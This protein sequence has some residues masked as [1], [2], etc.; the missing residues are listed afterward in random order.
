VREALA[1]RFSARVAGMDL[2][3]AML[4]R[5]LEKRTDT[6][7]V[8]LQGRAEAIPLKTAAVDLVFVSMVFHHFSDRALA[9]R[10]CRRVLRPNGSALVRTGTREHIPDYAYVDYFPST[11]CICEQRLPSKQQV[12]DVFREA[13]FHLAAH[14]VVTQQIAGSLA[15][16]VGKLSPQSDSVLASLSAEEYSSGVAAMQERAAREEGTPIIEPLDLF[17]LR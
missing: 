16:Y 11:R 7:V 6:R 1:G 13:G 14:E 12:G 4:R 2:A 3:A 9:A 5:A 10:E 17:V 8:Y 15:E